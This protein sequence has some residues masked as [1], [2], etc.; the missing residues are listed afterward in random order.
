MNPLQLAQVRWCPNLR[1]T[2]KLY[3]DRAR[4]FGVFRQCWHAWSGN[5]YHW[6]RT[7]T[8][9]IRLSILYTEYYCS[10]H[11]I[12]NSTFSIFFF[13]CDLSYTAFQYFINCFRS[14][15]RV[16][17][18]GNTTFSIVIAVQPSEVTL[19]FYQANIQTKL[20]PELSALVFLQ[21]SE[22]RATTDNSGSRL[23]DKYLSKLPICTVNTT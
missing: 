1:R 18:H 20:S 16:S 8:T 2:T 13:S 21:W 17:Y 22:G 3:S 12:T 19:I 7:R 5:F 6:I 15:I 11:F 14:P 4:G 10:A 9:M 23:C